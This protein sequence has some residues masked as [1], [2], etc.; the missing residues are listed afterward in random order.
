MDTVL[1]LLDRGAN[2][3]PNDMNSTP[4]AEACLG[5]YSELVYLLLVN[6][7][8][9]SPDQDKEGNTPLLIA[10]REGYALCVE[11]LTRYGASD[12]WTDGVRRML[13]GFLHLERK[14]G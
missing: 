1:V 7:A 4:L 11:L 13:V 14:E 9:A 3:Y 10:A 2:Q 8:N 5:G 12:L 6:G